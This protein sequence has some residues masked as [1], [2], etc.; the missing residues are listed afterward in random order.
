MLSRIKLDYPAIRKALLELDDIKLSFDDLK[1]ISRQ[2]PTPEEVNYLVYIFF[3]VLFTMHCRSKE[4]RVLRM[5]V[6][7][8]RQT[9]ISIR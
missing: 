3:P 1:A 7:S 9:N 5:L 4:S 8:Q 2:I 6:N